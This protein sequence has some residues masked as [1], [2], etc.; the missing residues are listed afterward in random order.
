MDSSLWTI[1]H[2][3]NGHV[4]ETDWAPKCLKCSKSETQGS[5]HF[6][7]WSLHRH[8]QT[9]F[10]STLERL[11]NDLILVFVVSHTGEHVC[12]WLPH[13]A[14]VLFMPNLNPLLPL[15][16][17]EFVLVKNSENK[18]RETCLVTL[19]GDVFLIFQTKTMLKLVLPLREQMF[20]V[21][22]AWCVD[23]LVVVSILG[24]HC[25]GGQ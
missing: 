8:N 5:L 7:P 20:I 11:S 13:H 3:F 1:K 24:L 25:I 9:A 19:K 18:R 22:I 2:V 12:H 10:F 17:A 21:Q 23:F 4:R 15:L 16:L 6:W 14:L